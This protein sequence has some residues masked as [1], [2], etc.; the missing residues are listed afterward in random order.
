MNYY[1]NRVL[2]IS[3]RYNIVSKLPY[4]L[5]IL[6]IICGFATYWALTRNIALG[7]KSRSVIFLIYLDLT[8]LLLLVFVVARKSVELWTE[9]RQGLKGSKLH[10]HIVILFVVVSVAPA[11]C[12]AFFSAQFFNIGVDAWFGKPVHDAL[13]E[14][15]VV[16]ESYLKEHKKSISFDIES[17]KRLYSP[18]MPSFVEQHEN[19]AHLDE[20]SENLSREA[21]E[22]GLAEILIFDNQ[23]PPRILGRSYLSFSLILE[24]LTDALKILK[25]DPQTPVI[26]ES[27]AKDRVRALIKL[28][29]S[30]DTYLL[31]G[32]FIDQKV[33]KHVDLTKSAIQDY[34][35]LEGQHVDVQFTFVAFF[36]IVALLLLM[37]AIWGGLVIADS[38]VKPITKLIAAAEAVA[39]G[40]L[41]IKL[42]T[43]AVNNEIDDLC[44][45]FNRMTHQLLQQ[46]H[47]LILSEKK[48]AWA[49][50]ARKI[51]HEIKNP[52]TPI[53]LSAERLKRRYLKE[54]T[55]DPKTFQA[56]VETIIRQVGSIGNLVNEFSNFARMPEPKFEFVNWIELCNHALFLQIQAHPEIEFEFESAYDSYFAWIDSFQMTQVLNNL[57]QNAINA[58]SE[59]KNSTNPPKIKLRLY[60]NNPILCVSIDDNGPGF[61]N[62]EKN[63]L[64]EPYYTTRDKGSGLGLAIVYR[65][66]SD[67]QGRIELKE[68]KDLK[69][70]SV[71]LS[72][73]N[74]DK[75][76]KDAN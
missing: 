24:D 65:I 15:S 32:K 31:V 2:S 42:E 47:D 10:A 70:A 61:P 9:K 62:I 55:S 60:E 6:A 21:D 35:R 49:D 54:I 8:L 13:Q 57:L 73:L 37:A 14:A 18:L 45:S 69:G 58:I 34:A 66:V 63:K 7:E 74:R 11:L 46:K 27:K 59:N 17:L 40:D 36:T 26:I 39:E 76:E 4:L 52:L 3:R 16:A 43:H 19:Q 50:M 68:S 33:L 23:K 38:M 12:V 64:L 25:K 29:Y 53:Q 51:A 28:D 67:H 20:L 5:S 44:R 75:K 71:V 41:S 72:F 56:C 22:R 1:Y 48:S 30:T